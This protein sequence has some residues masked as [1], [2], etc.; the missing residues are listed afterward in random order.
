MWLV[1]QA[2]LLILDIVFCAMCPPQKTSPLPLYIVPPPLLCCSL[3]PLSPSLHPFLACFTLLS[4]LTSSLPP[5][6][7]S[8]P[9]LHDVSYETPPFSP[10]CD[11]SPTI[12][13]L[14]ICQM[15]SNHLLFP[16]TSITIT[17]TINQE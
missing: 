11:S 16:G 14:T 5:L 7:P 15:L 4:S 12:L 6:A 10:V 1:I 13:S 3:P 8:H 17:V 9:P 2:I